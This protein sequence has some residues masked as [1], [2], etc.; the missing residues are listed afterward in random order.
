[1]GID[2]KTHMG[3]VGAFYIKRSMELPKKILNIV[4]FLKNE[5]KRGIM[6][7]KCVG[8]G[9]CCKQA[10][11][12]T[13]FIAQDTLNRN[14]LLKINAKLPKSEPECPFLYWDKDRYRCFLAQNEVYARFLAIGEGC[15]SSLNSERRKYGKSQEKTPKKS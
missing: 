6:F 4:N 14:P 8:C 2:V 7:P 5:A 13:S 10:R 3:V 1:M 12:A 9:Y 11:C 15:C